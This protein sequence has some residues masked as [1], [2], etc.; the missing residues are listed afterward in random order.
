MVTNV[1][2]V[3]V[4]VVV[5]AGLIAGALTGTSIISA[6]MIMHEITKVLI[7]FCLFKRVLSRC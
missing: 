6:A 2:A 7:A 1:V 5:S 4:V 3:A